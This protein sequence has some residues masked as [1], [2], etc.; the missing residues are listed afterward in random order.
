MFNV[1]CPNCKRQFVPPALSSTSDQIISGYE[2]AIA[3]WTYTGQE[4]YNRF[5]VMLTANAIILATLGLILTSGNQSHN[6]VGF[7]LS[8]SGFILCFGWVALNARNFIYAHY[9]VES[10]RN[11]E[12]HI[13]KEV[14]TV[15][16]GKNIRMEGLAKF[17][18]GKRV[19]NIIIFLFLFLYIGAT[20]L[21]LFQALHPGGGSLLLTSSLF[22]VRVDN[23]MNFCV[24]I[25]I[26]F[27][28]SIPALLFA[29]WVERQR[30]P[31][32]K[33]I[34]KEEANVDHTY[35]LGH[36]HSEER[37]K[38]FR[39]SVKNKRFLFPFGWIPRQAAEK[40]TAV[41]EFTKTGSDDQKFSLR[42]RWA[43]TPEIPTTPNAAILRILYPD[44]VT[45]P[46]NEEELLDV[47]TK[48]ENDKEAYGW[49]NEAYLHDWRPPEHKLERGNYRVKITISTQN[50]KTF[51][52]HFELRVADKI[53]D[54]F[55]K[56]S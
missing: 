16:N 31:N 14:A 33:M 25:L 22:F 17:G 54:C 24:E 30:L 48:N 3:L 11:L 13:G 19:T 26:A 28:G 50:G 43:S 40:C 39:V 32:L 46:P 2:A 45:I 56:K 51:I 27:I 20:F 41:V 55:L 12:E 1:T 15:R 52:E 4:V 35:L 34:A 29:L 6:K 7:V 21:F 18:V 8:V 44:P 53:E 49:S 42:G 23:Y 5:N 38:F 37:W 36:P 47:I 10:A 9:Y